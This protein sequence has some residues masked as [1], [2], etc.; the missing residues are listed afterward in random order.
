MRKKPHPKRA[1]RKITSQK[2]SHKIDLGLL[3]IIASLLTIG[4]L[5]V[6]ESSLV[7]AYNQFG[8]KFHFVKLQLKWIGFGLI[9]FLSSLLIPLN[10]LKKLSPAI[11]ISS[12]L[13]LILVLIPGIGTNVKGAQRWL[14]LGFFS[15]QPAEVTKLSLIIYLSALFEKTQKP[16]QFFS[17]L[18]FIT[19]LIMLQPDLGT[20]ITIA[21]TALTMFYISGAPLFYVL[22]SIGLGLFSALTLIL[23]SSYR[24]ARL[25][26][27][28]DPDRDPLGASYHIRQIIIALGSGGWFG[29]GFGRSLQKYRYLP[30]A[31]TD[32]IFAVIGE[33]TGFIGALL[34]ISLYLGLAFKGLSIAK[35]QTDRFYMLLA[36]GITI[37]LT[38]QAFMNLGAMTALVPLTGITLPLISYGGTSLLISLT[39]LGLLLNISKYQTKK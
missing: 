12:I 27:F 2:H 23:S 30:E 16:I 4:I 9:S 10:L 37:L 21:A 20:T 11:L 28:L 15:L 22:S 8:D 34:V 1:K 5:F 31:T 25:L 17:L 32:S 7:E 38:I 36:T 33:E 24:R 3:L 6:Y 35:N 39:S 13:L 14:D 19:F 29:T 26:T 18:G